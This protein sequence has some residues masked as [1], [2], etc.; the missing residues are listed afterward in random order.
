MEVGKTRSLSVVL[1]AA[2]RA[3]YWEL[4]ESEHV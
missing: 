1:M 4:G 2:V 3:N